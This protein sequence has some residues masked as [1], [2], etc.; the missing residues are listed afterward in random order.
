MYAVLI[1]S[2]LL[3]LLFLCSLLCY[4]LCK[5]SARQS[6]RDLTASSKSTVVSIALS[7]LSKRE[8]EG[9]EMSQQPKYKKANLEIEIPQTPRE[10]S[11]TITM[12]T[13]QVETT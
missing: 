10:S 8:L 12:E 7:A 9:L 11:D 3:A 5:D 1:Y 13:V 4:L 6:A 2:L